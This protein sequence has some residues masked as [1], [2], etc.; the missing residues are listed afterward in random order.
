[1]TYKHWI[2]PKGIFIM[3]IPVDWQYKNDIVEGFE[4]ISPYSF[5]RYGNASGAFQISCYK[6]SEKGNPEWPVYETKV[7]Y[8]NWLKV[9]KNYDD[10]YEIIFHYAQIDDTLVMVKIISEPDER[11]EQDFE[12]QLEFSKQVM[13]SVT[14][15]PKCDRELAVKHRAYDNFMSSI[16]AAFDLRNRAKENL[17]V[18][19]VVILTSNIIDAYLRLSIVMT[20]QLINV[21]DDFDV[22]Y[23]FEGETGKGRSEGKIYSE[24]NQL[25]IIDETELEALNSLY[26]RRNKVVHR[27]LISKIRTNDVIKLADDYNSVL[28]WITVKL[29]S[30][31]DEQIDAGVGLYSVGYS[32]DYVPTNEDRSIVIS[33]AMDKHVNPRLNDDLFLADK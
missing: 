24:A 20:T 22:K 2:E 10:G 14:I 4:E 31:E 12:S 8:E 30:I 3:N 7:I 6:I 17:S 32:K 33:M 23:L 29:K 16:M 15:I 19:E 25:K 27:F 5:V 1:M 21:S 26:R 18:I 9:I 28:E 13:S 11:D